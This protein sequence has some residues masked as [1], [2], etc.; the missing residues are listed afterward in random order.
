MA[1]TEFKT[2]HRITEIMNKLGI[3]DEDV[4]RIYYAFEN[5]I[6]LK[7]RVPDSLKR[8]NEIVFTKEKDK[9]ME[10]M[11]WVNECLR[12]YGMQENVF[13]DISDFETSS[14]D[15][16]YYN[17]YKTPSQY[18]KEEEERKQ[19]KLKNSNEILK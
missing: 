19:K 14:E 13:R 1:E 16:D 17:E 15:Y 9:Y 12:A 5:L 11:K 18:K 2:E 7:K 6:V 10:K 3:Y 8:M 4:R